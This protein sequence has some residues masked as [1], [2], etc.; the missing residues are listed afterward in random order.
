MTTEKTYTF[1]LQIISDLHKDARGYRPRGYNFSTWSNDDIQEFWDMLLAELVE[2]NLQKAVSEG[3]AEATFA[4][5]IVKTIELGADDYNTA[6]R[7]ISQSYESKY[8]HSQ[9]VEGFIWEQGFLFTEYGSK[10]KNELMELVE[11]ETWE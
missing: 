2:N 6:L 7:W 9:D 4:S 8:H 5:L 11:F 3:E 10:I 1:D